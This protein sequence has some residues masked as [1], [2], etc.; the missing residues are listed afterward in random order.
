MEKKEVKDLVINAIIC[1]SIIGI[2]SA[3]FR[4]CQNESDMRKCYKNAENNTSAAL[5]ID[6]KLYI[7]DNPSDMHFMPN[8][9]YLS[10]SFNDSNNNSGVNYII[11]DERK[12]ENQ[13]GYDVTYYKEIEYNIN[14]L[15]SKTMVIYT[16]SDDES[17]RELLTR[18][19]LSNITVDDENTI[20]FNKNDITSDGFKEYKYRA[21]SVNNTENVEQENSQRTRSIFEG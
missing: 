11:N 21:L 16:Y 19:I 12:G 1:G 14:Y 9:A 10:K 7:Y 5:I 17:S 2:S 4:S 20:I 15:D 6:G 8:D 3:V 18:Y 13:V